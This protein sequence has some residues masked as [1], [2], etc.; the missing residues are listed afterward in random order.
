MGKL[1]N[2][3]E[4]EWPSNSMNSRPAVNGSA[5]PLEI[6]DREPSELSGD[7]TDSIHADGEVVWARDFERCVGY[8]S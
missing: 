2:I 6:M 3:S 1:V 8:S 4:G 7:A 5:L